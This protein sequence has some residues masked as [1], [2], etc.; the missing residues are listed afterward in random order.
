M[1]E[2]IKTILSRRSIRAYEPRRISD[3]E[4]ETLLECALYAPTG[5]NLQNSRFLVIQ[6]P[7]LM[8][9]LNQV[10]RDELSSREIVEGEMMAKGIRRARQE[11]YHFIFHA[12]TLITAVAP[13]NHSNSM[14]N[15]CMGLENILIAAESLGLGACFSNQPHWLTDVPV[16]REIFGRLGLREEEDIFGSVSVGYPAMRPQKAAAR[17]EGRICLDRDVLKEVQEKPC[18]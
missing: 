3:K 7:A 13:K 16:V 4:L 9:E 8:E 18:I 15:C 14:A 17:K 2:T 5:G 12:P 1:N 6:S 11:G 10:I